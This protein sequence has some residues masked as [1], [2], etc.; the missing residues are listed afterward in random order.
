MCG[1]TGWF[2]DHHV[3]ATPSS[4]PGHLTMGCDFKQKLS[5]SWWGD[6]SEQKDE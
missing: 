1:E 2:L 5:K 3:F 4:P 6:L